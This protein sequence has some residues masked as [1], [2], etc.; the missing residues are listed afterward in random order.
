MRRPR[1]APSALAVLAL[2]LVVAPVAPQAAALA[3]DPLLAATVAAAAPAA[4]EA[5]VWFTETT[6]DPGTSYALPADPVRA[7][8]G[9]DYVLAGAYAAR[10]AGPVLLLRAAA[11]AT[12]SA[13]TPVAPGAEAVLG[14]GDAVVY[15]DYAAAWEARNP[16]PGP[17]RVLGGGI[18]SPMGAFAAGSPIVYGQLPAG[19]AAA[20]VGWPA[21]VRMPPPPTAVTITAHRL[22]LGP[23]AQLP[24]AGPDR[25]QA[26][27]VVAG[28]G[29]ALSR[30]QDGSAQNLGEAPVT[31]V[32]LAIAVDDTSPGTPP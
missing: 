1:L 24:A 26:V 23:G 2:L 30:P 31:V 28:D 20:V 27:A 7:G 29:A 21:S 16:G 17:A 22:T 4:G 13:A 5:T 14:P 15:L 18:A 19:V 9:F 11:A 12:P 3:A 25:G 8:V 32:L 10:S 6:W